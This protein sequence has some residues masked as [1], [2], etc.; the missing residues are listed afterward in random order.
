MIHVKKGLG[1]CF[2]GIDCP[3]IRRDLAVAEE[4]KNIRHG[5]PGRI[6]G[7][8]ARQ[9][10]S[11]GNF[12]NGVKTIQGINAA[13]NPCAADNPAFFDTAQGVPESFWP[14]QF[15][16]FGD[17]GNGT[18][19]H[20]GIQN[21]L[22]RLLQQGQLPLSVSGG[23]DPAAQCFCQADGCIPQRAGA[24]PYKQCVVPAKL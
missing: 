16:G 7:E 13:E 9:I 24:A 5:L 21:G 23:D 22:V 19:Q 14:Y 20:S 10:Y 15:Q 2:K 17:A 12:L 6:V 4:G 11:I 18:G 3:C 1:D 8:K